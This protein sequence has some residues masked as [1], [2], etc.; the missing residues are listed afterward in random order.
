MVS[1]E[2][3]TSSPW[4]GFIPVYGSYTVSHMQNVP[5]K[6]EL[7]KTEKEETRMGA[8]FEVVIS[9]R[10]CELQIKLPSK[11]ALSLSFPIMQAHED[12]EPIVRI[13]DLKKDRVNFV[14]ENVDLAY[15]RL[16]PGIITELM[17]LLDSQTLYEES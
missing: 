14:L 15:G 4:R 5:R 13:R 11:L 7:Q 2:M 1:A 12:L 16:S 9:G 6:L 17:L 10:H 3:P 8:L